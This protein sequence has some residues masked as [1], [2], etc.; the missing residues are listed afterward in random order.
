MQ[1]LLTCSASTA[2]AFT[3]GSLILLTAEAHDV[4]EGCERYTPDFLRLLLRHTP[5]GGAGA[6]R[7]PPQGNVSP[8][9]CLSHIR[10]TSLRQGDPKIACPILHTLDAPG[11]LRLSAEARSAGRAL[12]V[13]SSRDFE[14][15][16]GRGA[17]PPVALAAE[18][19][20]AV[21][22]GRGGPRAAYCKGRGQP[23]NEQVEGNG[24]QT[25]AG[26]HSAFAQD[27]IGLTALTE[28]SVSSAL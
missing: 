4:G 13:S 10:P 28:E 17:L 11:V 27:D 5:Q 20:G 6:L 9:V 16:G 24:G 21:V 26:Y 8:P 25:P 14:P 12:E 18:V 23:A 3:C 19:C 1:I 2:I 7:C 15:G 22:V